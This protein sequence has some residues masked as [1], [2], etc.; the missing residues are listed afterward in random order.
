MAATSMQRL[1]S[2]HQ[3]LGALPAPTL[4]A[5]SVL[6]VAASLLAQ[7]APA[8]ADG[9]LTLRGVYYK[10]RAT[11][12][13]EPILDASSDVGDHGEINGNLA[14]DVITSASVAAGADAKA[15]T[16]KRY[17]AGGGYAHT[18]GRYRISGN[19]RYS[20][21]SDYVARYLGA[22]LTIDLAE[23][24][25]QLAL[26]GGQSRDDISN[27]GAQSPFATLF[28]AEMKSTMAFLSVTQLLG[29]NSVVGVSAD[30][31]SISG[32]QANP[33]RL[34]ITNQ[35]L[36]A[37]RHPNERLRQAY[38]VT[39]RYFVATTATTVIGVYRYYRD[40]WEIRAHTPEV[41]VV[42][43]VGDTVEAAIRFRYHRQSRAYFYQDRYDSSDV[44]IQPFLTDDVK[45]SRFTTKTLEAKLAVHGDTFG[46]E[47]RWGAARLEGML[48]YVVQDNRFGNAA[49]AHL[50][51]TVPFGGVY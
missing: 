29:P 13:E 49:I 1:V 39:G 24:N 45:L 7:P 20:T 15:F 3:I 28:E 22:G 27:A 51:V 21:E 26:G 48:Q 23:K 35:G 37:E 47:G 2:L 42:Q 33:Y 17:E 40:D 6:G 38:A 4:R 9:E 31:A 36:I 14:I 41:R 25:T 16:E 19:G 43:E 32:F 5:L 12:V 10:E 30:V 44:M 8:A 18:I 50:A 46:I 11:R 34:A